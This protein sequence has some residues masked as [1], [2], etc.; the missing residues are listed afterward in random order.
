MTWRSL[1]AAA[2]LSA[3]V[4]FGVFAARPSAFAPNDF[5]I[6]YCAG[7][8]VDRGGNPY[9]AQPLGACEHRHWPPGMLSGVSEPAALPGY[10]L[11]PFMLLALLPFAVA[12]WLWLA[13]SCAAFGLAV[14]AGSKLSKMSPVAIFGLL[15]VP[16]AV[17]NIGDGQLTVFTISA[18]LACGVY[19]RS[20]RPQLAAFCALGALLQ[21]HI[22]LPLLAGLFVLVRGTRGVLAAALAVLGAVHLTVLGLQPALAYF[23]AVLPAM[24]RAEIVASDQYGTMWWLHA[25][26]VPAV[27]ASRISDLAYVAA[28]AG[29]IALASTAR[30]RN[31]DPSLAAVLPVAVALPFAPYLHDIELGAALGA[32]LAFLYAAPYDRRWNAVAVLC[33]TPWYGALH[34][35]ALAVKC[36][37]GSWLFFLFGLRGKE[38]IAWMAAAACAAAI[39]FAFRHPFPDR[40]FNVA[41]INGELAAQSWGRYLASVPWLH[42]G[43]PQV[44][45]P[46][47]VSWLALLA[48]PA[49]ALRAKT[50]W[51]AAAA[52]A[53]SS[54]I[55]MTSLHAPA[56]AASTAC[57]A[58]ARGGAYTRDVSHDAV[59]LHSREFIDSMTDAGN[60]FGFYA[61][62]GVEFVN[63]ANDRTPRLAVRQKVSWHRFDTRYPWSPTYRIEPL[64]DAHAIVVQNGSCRLYELYSASFSGGVLSAYSGADWDLRGP[65][66]PLPAGEPSSMS[67]GLS[68]YA[69]MVKWEEYAGGTI[70]HALNWAALRGTVSQYGYVPP[71]SDTNATSFE[72]ASRYQLPWGAHLRLKAS[73]DTRSWGPQ[74]RAVAR[75]MKI[76]GIYL[77]DTGSYKNG[78]YF[79]NALDGS[80]PWDAR[81]L[82]AL[83]SLRLSDFEVL[84]LP[85]LQRVPGH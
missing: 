79:A 11:V 82:E 78:L 24:S 74:A 57:P 56:A 13:I 75:A 41:A 5:A 14:A 28:V 85:A 26:G 3:I 72:G 51:A 64:A 22:A 76:Y 20:G 65:F 8:V 77:A 38:R 59:D 37:L 39:V 55:V 21:P 54:V 1:T 19:L 46:K 12:K 9:E 69:G 7:Q 47:L 29:G 30:R 73:Y 67:S 52:I 66:E 63:V 40:S 6:F 23:T 31:A 80:N 35:A 4:A 71:A 17:L 61:S 58:F 34:S 25:A 10:G 70:D 27:A 18:I 83:D 15:F 62:T 60:T 45:L 43:G 44:V 49:I 33:A 48:I 50:T 81:D 32:P 68:L 2:L 84:R 36:L 53:I 16:L 42:A